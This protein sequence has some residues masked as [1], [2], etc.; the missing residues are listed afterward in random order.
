MAE[1]MGT[2][3]QSDTESMLK[4]YFGDDNNGGGDR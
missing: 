4:G 1:S 2:L 3:L